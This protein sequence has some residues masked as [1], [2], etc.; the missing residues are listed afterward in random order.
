MFDRF[1]QIVIGLLEGAFICDSTMPEA[2]RILNE[3][4]NR[5]AVSDY[6]DKIGRR[7]SRT[8]GG[9]AYY[10]TWKRVSNTE[11]TE[12][13]KVFSVIKQNVR[14]VIQFITLCMEVERKDVTPAPGDRLD[15]PALLKAITGSPHFTEMLREFGNMGKEFAAGDASTKSMLDKVFKQM[16]SYGYIKNVSKEFET[17]LFTGKLDYYYQVIDFLM[18][19]EN[20]SD[21]AFIDQD[22]EPEQ[23]RLL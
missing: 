8:P 20:I 4:Q 11:R 7:L 5:Q 3:E 17:Y 2:F 1:D 12:V 23:A 14:P 18:E 22:A 21:P 16:E 15:Y 9:Q 13:K 6:L 19:N 10:A